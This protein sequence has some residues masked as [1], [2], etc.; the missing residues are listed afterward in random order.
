MNVHMFRIPLGKMK[1]VL[2]AAEI[3]LAWMRMKS[4]SVVSERKADMAALWPSGGTSE[5]LLLVSHTKVNDG[6][7]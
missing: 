1:V 7:L 2:P 6:L 5:D 4:A 3:P